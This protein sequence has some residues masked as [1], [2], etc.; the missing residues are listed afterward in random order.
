MDADR[1]SSRR[2]A[3]A[4]R[5]ATSRAAR[6]AR[7]P[8]GR[9]A[10][11]HASALPSWEAAAPVAP[12]DERHVP[13]MTVTQQPV[14]DRLVRGDGPWFTRGDAEL[15]ERHQPPMCP[16]PLGVHVDAE[17]AV[18]TLPGEKCPD[19][20]PSR[21]CVASSEASSPSR[22]RAPASG[23]PART[24]PGGA[25]WHAPASSRSSPSP[26]RWCRDQTVR[27]TR[28]ALESGTAPTIIAG[29]HPAGTGRPRTSAIY[30]AGKVFWPPVNVGDPHV[31]L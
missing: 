4:T 27:S 20:D 15:D 19:G 5:P 12:V 25:R 24:M 18:V 6:H 22:S 21:T 14:E 11:R 10:H 26:R 17:P 31:Y 7:Q 9:A 16:A 2:P 8:Q 30:F 13:A 23:C 3:T 1:N 29:Q 28:P